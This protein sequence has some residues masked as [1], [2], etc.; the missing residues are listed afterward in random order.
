MPANSAFLISR[1]KGEKNLA[2]SVAA[3][4]SSIQNETSSFTPAPVD[5]VMNLFSHLRA[6]TTQNAPS[7]LTPPLRNGAPTPP[8]N[9]PCRVVTIDIL[10]KVQCL[11]LDMT[12]I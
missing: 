3:L 5:P 11:C 8:T 7:L 4:F 2:P 1:R 9:R 12:I 6:Q 10:C